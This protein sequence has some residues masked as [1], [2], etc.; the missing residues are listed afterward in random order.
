[1]NQDPACQI[2]DF[3]RHRHATYKHKCIKPVITKL[4]STNEGERAAKLM[5]MDELGDHTPFYPTELAEHHLTF[6]N[7][8]FCGRLPQPM[9]QNR[10]Q[11]GVFPCTLFARRREKSVLHLFW[12]VPFNQPAEHPAC[13]RASPGLHHF[14]HERISNASG[15]NSRCNH[16]RMHYGKSSLCCQTPYSNYRNWWHRASLRKSIRVDVLYGTKGFRRLE[17]LWRLVPHEQSNTIC[18]YFERSPLASG[19]SANSVY[20]DS[21]GWVAQYSCEYASSIRSLELFLQ[22]LMFITMELIFMVQT[23]YRGRYRPLWLP[24]V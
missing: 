10:S 13:K 24:L 15:K 7:A 23:R 19:C 3:L 16:M 9:L 1:M 12:D 6:V 2:T 14:L 20:A 22:L 21:H 4:F 8:V 18:L 5:N 17:T 11:W